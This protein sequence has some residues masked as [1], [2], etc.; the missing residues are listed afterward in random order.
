MVPVPRTGPEGM[1]HLESIYAREVRLV[2]IIMYMFS[3]SSL[4]NLLPV[5]V[6]DS[7]IIRHKIRLGRKGVA[8]I[9]SKQ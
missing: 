1:G 2:C 9:S 4:R 6:N 3:H 8:N 5:N 7:K